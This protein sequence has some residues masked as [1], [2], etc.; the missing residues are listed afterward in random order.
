[1]SQKNS[2]NLSRKSIVDINK[3][4]H[5]EPTKCRRCNIKTATF[6]H[7]VADIGSTI[8]CQKCKLE[9]NPPKMCLSL[10]RNG[11]L[12]NVTGLHLENEMLLKNFE[13]CGWFVRKEIIYHTT[14]SR[15]AYDLHLEYFGVAHC[16][17]FDN[18]K[19]FYPGMLQCLHSP[20]KKHRLTKSGIIGTADQYLSLFGAN[21]PY[22]L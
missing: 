22:R 13:E 6:Y 1:M 18:Y 14:Q 21:N 5:G 4:Y 8:I 3:R 2:T 17:R 16:Q 10:L 12:W 19:F 7:E 20:C 9:L 15:Q 11:K